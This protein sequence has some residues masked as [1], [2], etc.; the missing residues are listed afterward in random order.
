MDK[1]RKEL[2]DRIKYNQ[3]HL[4]KF[5][6][7]Q[8]TDFDDEL[9]RFQQ[10]QTKQYKIKKETLK[11]E[12]LNSSNRGKTEK[13][14]EIRRLKD[15]LQSKL[16]H[17]EQT[18]KTQ[19]HHDQNVRRLQLKRRKLL[20]LHVLEQK[21]SE[22]VRSFVFFLFKLLN[23]LSLAFRNVQKQWKQSHN[24]IFFL[25]NITSKPKNSNTNNS[26]LYTSKFPHSA[27]LKTIRSH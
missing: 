1:H 8:Q 20:L 17:D 19:L 2:A 21:L 11:K 18:L 10:E 13:E 22:E 23:F 14:D 6:R 27:L 26:L 16:R 24:V 4:R 3:N 9:K 7:E 12:V 25:K 15:D 5:E